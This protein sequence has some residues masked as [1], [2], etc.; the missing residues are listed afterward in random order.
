MS[1]EVNLIVASFEHCSEL[2]L[3]NKELA[4]CGGS[5][6]TMSIYELENRMHN[7]ISSGYIAIIFEVD[8]IH[9]GYTLIKKNISPMFIRH[10]FITEKYRHLGYGTIAFK[11]TINFLNVD[12]IDLSVLMSNDIGLKFWKSCGLVPYEVRMHYRENK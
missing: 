8:G 9:I 11:K 2:A 7:F 1:N 10:F 6:N 3:F 4:D 12:K 5:H